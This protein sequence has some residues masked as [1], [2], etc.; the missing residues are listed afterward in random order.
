MTGG[1]PETTPSTP[2]RKHGSPPRTQGLS[3]GRAFP[4]APWMLT[5]PRSTHDE[6]MEDI[7]GRAFV[8]PLVASHPR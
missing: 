3:A 5:S 2:D 6:P 1:S 4:P 8:A 7:T